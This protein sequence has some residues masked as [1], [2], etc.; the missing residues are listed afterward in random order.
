M[1]STRC[2]AGGTRLAA[3]TPKL[4][5]STDPPSRF[6]LCRGWK[7]IRP[8]GRQSWP[9][10]KKPLVPEQLSNDMRELLEAL[11]R[12]QAQYL[13]IGAHAVGAYTEPRG[14]KDLD[15]WVNPTKGN[16]KRVHAAL[17]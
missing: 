7:E 6:I 16:A 14:T 4:N 2:S 11:N 17:K 15:I 1:R 10:R 3:S 13:I 9:R 8:P 5:E 12:W